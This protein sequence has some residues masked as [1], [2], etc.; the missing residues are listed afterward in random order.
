MDF[1]LTEQEKKAICEDPQSIKLAIN[2]HESQI[3]MEE[4]MGFS[5]KF[6]YKRIKE[7][8]EMDKEWN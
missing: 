7:L 2:Y 1:K 6:H 5:C 3:A 4:S 8:K